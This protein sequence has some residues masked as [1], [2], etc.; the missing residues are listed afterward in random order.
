MILF[1]KVLNF[2]YLKKDYSK[3]EKKK[4]ISNNLF[5]YEND[6]TYPVHVSDEKFKSCVSLL[7]ITDENCIL[8]YLK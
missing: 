1:M 4:N 6:L 2:L 7:M 3:T 5:C 8:K